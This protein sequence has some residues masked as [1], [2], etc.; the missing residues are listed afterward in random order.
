MKTFKEISEVS[1]KLSK[2]EQQIIDSLVKNEF[3]TGRGRRFADA[4]KKLLASGLVADV[5]IVHNAAQA[6]GNRMGK[7]NHNVDVTVYSFKY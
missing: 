7:K 6:P 2:T 3:V 4:A 1:K 5:K